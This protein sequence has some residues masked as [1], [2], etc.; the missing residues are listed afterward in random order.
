VH[1]IEQKIIVQNNTNKII[2]TITKYCFIQLV[3]RISVLHWI[4]CVIVQTVLSQK[5]SYVRTQVKD[6]HSLQLPGTHETGGDRTHS[7]FSNQHGQLSYI[8]PIV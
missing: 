4:K 8:L 7:P 5:P 6:W 1:C 3:N 2:V